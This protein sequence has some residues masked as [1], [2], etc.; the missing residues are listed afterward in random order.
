MDSGVKINAQNY[1]DD[2]LKKEVLPWAQRHFGQAN[3]TY[4]QDSAP[5]HKANVVQAWCKGNFPDF[6]SSAEWPP[7]SPDLNP[8]DYSVWGIMKAKVG[9][10]RHPN[11]TSLRKALE[12]EWDDL[13]VCRRGGVSQK[14][15]GMYQGKRRYL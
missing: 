10:A 14:T 8:L 13:D 12:K 15:Q 1:L 11:L 7:N 5:A 4:Q 3:W 2:I 9:A 6:I